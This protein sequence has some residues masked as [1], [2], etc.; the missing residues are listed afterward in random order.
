MHGNR[1]DHRRR[2][3]GLTGDCTLAVVTAAGRGYWIQL[4]TASDEAPHYDERAWFEE[5]LA[6]VQL[7][8]EDAVDSPL[9]SPYRFEAP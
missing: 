1:A 4:Y 9:S 5:I 7:Q 6:T 3:Q 8:P 2:R